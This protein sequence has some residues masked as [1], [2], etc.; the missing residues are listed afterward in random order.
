MNLL[1]T[2]NEYLAMKKKKNKYFPCIV[3]LIVCIL[4]NYFIKLRK[5]ILILWCN[6]ALVCGVVGHNNFV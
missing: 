3:S 6:V 4:E 5:L 1:F 2:K